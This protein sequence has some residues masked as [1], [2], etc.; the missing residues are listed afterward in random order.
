VQDMKPTSAH[1]HQGGLNSD[2][3]VIL[4]LNKT[5][6]TTFSVPPNARLTEEQYARFR[7]GNLYVNVHSEPYPSGE[8][9]AQLAP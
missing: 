9:R 4:P 2:G 5:S 1:I 8:I 7:E 6:E 3:P